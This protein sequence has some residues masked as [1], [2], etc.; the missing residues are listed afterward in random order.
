M[1][2]IELGLLTKFCGLLRAC[3]FQIGVIERCRFVGVMDLLMNRSNH[4][5]S[6]KYQGVANCQAGD[7]VTTYSFLRAET[8]GFAQGSLC[9]A[10]M[11]S[12]T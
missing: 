11:G 7:S 5:L 1:L 2:G 10:R 9:R 6:L 4:T 8:T 12:S 3:G